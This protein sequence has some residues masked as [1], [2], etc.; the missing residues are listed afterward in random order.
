MTQQRR[1]SFKLKIIEETDSDSS[2]E[3]DSIRFN[4]QPQ[5][6]EYTQPPEPTAHELATKKKR[7]PRQIVITDELKEHMNDSGMRCQRC[8]VRTMDVNLR[9]D[10]VTG[11]SEGKTR[12]VKHAECSKC[13]G[14]KLVYGKLSD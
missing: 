1:K 10:T 2:S 5:V 12:D 7:K 14:K 9:A 4:D 3:M 6:H 11:K 13:G 8:G